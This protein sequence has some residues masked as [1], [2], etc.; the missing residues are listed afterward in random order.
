M[1]IVIGK[2]PVW[3]N[4]CNAFQINPGITLFTYGDAIYNPGGAQITDDLMIHE[5]VHGKQQKHNDDEAAL[6][7]G[8][9]LRDP[10]F[11]LSQELEAYA[12]QYKFLCRKIQN[13]Q[14]RFEI[15][16]RMA[17]ILSGPLYGNCISFGS[18]VLKISEKAHEK[19]NTPSVC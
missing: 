14:Q 9:Y 8:K 15:V 13:K 6:W 7:W 1:K 10:E 16:K 2:P 19:D 18:A 11:R 12:E 3:N 17:T 5:Q 4:V